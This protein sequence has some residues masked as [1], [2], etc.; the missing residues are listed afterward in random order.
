M[1][2]KGKKRR[3]DEMMERRKKG[4]NEGRKAHDRI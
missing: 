4:M 3:M 2:M 1:F